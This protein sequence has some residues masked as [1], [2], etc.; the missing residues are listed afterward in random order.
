MCAAN[1][2]RAVVQSVDRAVSVLEF[3][4][5]EGWSGV[6]EVAN[7]LKVHKSTAHR[8]LV[9]LKERGLVEQDLETERY[10]LGLGLVFLASAVRAEL[11]VVRSAGPVCQRLHEQ[12]QETVTISVLA[13]DEVIVVYQTN[14]SASVFST[15]WKG[16]RLPLHCTSDGKVLLAH[17]PDRWQRC[18]ATRPLERFTAH[19]IVDPARLQEQLQTIRVD[20]Y[21]Y[22]V[23]E[24]EV[25]LNAVAAP[26]YAADG[27][28]VATI[29]VS[30]PTFR[31]P[32]KAIPEVGALARTAAAEISRRLGFTALGSRVP[33]DPEPAAIPS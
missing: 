31:L 3:L 1:D 15:D 11:D 16:R 32:A 29:G 17:H 21:G 23:E 22:T 10:R 6:T 24:L 27:T 18:I 20:G 26:I 9:T 25:G 33:Q 7:G 12:T 30:G 8:L 14:S 19:T 28:V 13:G 4:S 5:R 2:R